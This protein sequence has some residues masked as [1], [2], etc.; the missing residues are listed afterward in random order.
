MT[1][2]S[3]WR[4]GYRCAITAG[5]HAFA[6]DEPTSV[7]GGDAGP[8]PTELLLAAV[9]SCFTMALSHA[10]TRRGAL[11][12]DDLEVHVNGEYDGPRFQRI[13]VQVRTAS[14]TEQVERL[15]PA[16]ARVCYVSNTLRRSTEVDYSVKAVAGD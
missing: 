12:P 9:A 5:R 16:A 8:T 10:A 2:I 3:R 11:L 7:G 14:D 4:G 15:L 13:T 1:V 6:A